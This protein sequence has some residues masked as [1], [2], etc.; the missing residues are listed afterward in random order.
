MERPAS[1]SEPITSRQSRRRPQ[2]CKRCAVS[3]RRRNFLRS[4]RLFFAEFLKSRIAAQLVPI[5]INPELGRRERGPA[6]VGCEQMLQPSDGIVLV[7]KP[8]LDPGKIFFVARPDKSIFRRREQGDGLSGILQGGVLIAKAAA[9]PAQGAGEFGIVRLTPKSG[10]VCLTRPGVC[11]QGAR[12]IARKT[13]KIAEEVFGRSDSDTEFFWFFQLRFYNRNRVIVTMRQDRAGGDRA[14]CT[15]ISRFRLHLRKRLLCFSDI[16]LEEPSLRF[17]REQA[18]IS[19]VQIQCAIDK[20]T[21][22]SAV[23]HAS[24][25]KARIG[26]QEYILWIKVHRLSEKRAAVFPTPFPAC[27][28]SEC[29]RRVEIIWGL[30]ANRFE[31]RFTTRVIAFYPVMKESVGQLSLHQRWL[32]GLG[33][34]ERLLRELATRSGWLK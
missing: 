32:Q 34:F 8:R 14:D 7:S 21:S 16:A 19:R 13:K 20:L 33:L 28:R 5:G 1:R 31:A 29:I 3:A 9:G 15:E 23:A 12:S 4:F 2:P 22:A 30:F 26:Q 24:Q 17:K 25:I 6:V 27:H 18:G 11:F 10:F